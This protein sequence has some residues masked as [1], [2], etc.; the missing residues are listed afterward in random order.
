MSSIEHYIELLSKV[1]QQYPKFADEKKLQELR[2]EFGSKTFPEWLD[3]IYIGEYPEEQNSENFHR[4]NK[5]PK[6][7]LITEYHCYLY[8]FNPTNKSGLWIVEYLMTNYADKFSEIM[9]YF[10]ALSHVLSY[11]DDPVIDEYNY[12]QIPIAAQ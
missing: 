2:E 5:N 4:D 3:T 1:Y 12:Y 6:F 8:Y 7:W 9:S 10:R 11:K